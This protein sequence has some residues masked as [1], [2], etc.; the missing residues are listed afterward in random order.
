MNIQQLKYFIAVAH[1]LNFSEA[2]KHL[3]IAQPA[4]SQGIARLEKELNVKL[5]DRDTHSVALTAAGKV[6]LQEVQEIVKRLDLAVEKAQRTHAGYSGHLRI[7]FLSSLIKIYF[8]QW[9]PGFRN[10]Y[11]HVNLSFNQLF[12]EPLRKALEKGYVDIGVTRSFDLLLSPD[13]QWHKICDDGIS[14]VLRRDHPLADSLVLDFD[15]LAREPFIIAASETSPNWHKKVL[16]ICANRGFV[17]TFAHTPL[18]IETVYTLLQA[19]LGIA[20]LP[21][22]GKVHNL[23]KLKFIPL[24]GE[25]TKIDVVVAWNKLNTNPTIPLFLQEI[26]AVP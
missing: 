4:L 1:Y 7:G 22:S 21:N 2:S 16:Q 5:F 13:L 26:V 11:Q 12:M 20:F 3:F 24:E 18:A 19:G 6:F 10:K 15:A 25:D 23:P 8:P 9:I 14:L 17:P